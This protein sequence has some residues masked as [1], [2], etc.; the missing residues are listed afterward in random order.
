MDKVLGKALVE[1]F[2]ALDGPL[3]AA[4]ALAEDIADENERKAIRGAIAEVGMTIYT[5]LIRPVTRIY[6]DLEPPD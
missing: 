6:P 2:L 1:H 5:D 4:A 3:N